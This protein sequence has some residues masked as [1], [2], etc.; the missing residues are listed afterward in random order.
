[1]FRPLPDVLELPQGLGLAQFCWAHLQ[2]TLKG[3]G[4]FASTEDA[5]Y[6]ARPCAFTALRCGMGGEH[7]P[8]WIL[9][10]R[11]RLGAEETNKRQLMQEPPQ[12]TG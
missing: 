2:P 4:E 11:T 3:I 8:D 12:T 1:M 7:R 9:S 5:V 10:S 6:F